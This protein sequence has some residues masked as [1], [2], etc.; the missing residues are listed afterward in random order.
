MTISHS[1]L[2][3]LLDLTGKEFD[4]QVKQ[5]RDGIKPLLNS[6]NT[7]VS[8]MVVVMWQLFIVNSVLRTRNPPWVA[9]GNQLAPVS[10]ADDCNESDSDMSWMSFSP[11]T[12]D[13]EY[14]T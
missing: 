8:I 14:G 4:V 12:S 2:I 5:W 9:T 11:V 3:R 6:S 10:D 13:D 7:C 1:S